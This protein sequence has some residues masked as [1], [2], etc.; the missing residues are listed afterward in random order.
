M[1]LPACLVP[2]ACLAALVACRGASEPAKQ[3]AQTGQAV[4]IAPAE[5]GGL[6]TPEQFAAIADPL[7]RSRA[8][9]LEASQVMLHPRCTNCHPAGDS[10]LQGDTAQI[11]DP[12]VVRGPANEGVPGL[13]CTSCHQDANLEL[14]RVPGAPKWHLAP[15]E[16]A[17]VGLTPAALCQQ[18]KDPKR[19]GGKTLA[20]IVEHSAHDELVA[21]GWEPGHGRT[22]VPGTQAQF[23]ALMAAWVADGA[24]CPAG[25]GP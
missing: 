15:I 6:R 23:G 16:M 14:A 19:N 17:W 24:A 3:Q 5:P 20:Q 1:R 22:P 2:C 8:L 10:P 18:I 9:F 13:Q 7:E 4:T 25:E 21:W 11:H 12:P